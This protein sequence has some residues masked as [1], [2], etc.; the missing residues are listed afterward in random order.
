[1]KIIHLLFIAFLAIPLTAQN[2]NEK[3]I[4]T[5]VSGVTVFLEGAQVVRHKNVTVN[6][7]ISILKFTNLSPFIDAK[8]VQVKAEGN[9]T[10]LSVNHQ[11]NFLNELKCL[12]LIDLVVFWRFIV[13]ED[14]SLQSL[15]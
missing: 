5:D 1:M 12:Q 15:Q 10:V 2:N 11:Q 7:G 4:S 8:S 3:E 14:V 9:I 6:S 13:S